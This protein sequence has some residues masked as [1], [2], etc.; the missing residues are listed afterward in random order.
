M[1]A[2]FGISQN[3]GSEGI[4]RG[5]LSSDLEDDFLSVERTKPTGSSPLLKQGGR[6]PRWISTYA[7]IYRAGPLHLVPVAQFKN[8]LTISGPVVPAHP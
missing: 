8:A 1:A 4:E 2:Y 3:A 6:L 7:H 5:L